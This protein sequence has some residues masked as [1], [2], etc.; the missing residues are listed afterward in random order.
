MTG[1][2]V[3]ITGASSGIGA[4]LAERLA[5]DG[6]S[7]ALVARRPDAL[8]AVGERC[9]ANAMAIVPATRMASGRA[10]VRCCSSSFFCFDAATGDVLWS[11]RANG[12][13]SGSPTIIA[14]RVYFATLAQRTYALD[15]ATGHLVW[16]FPDGKYSPVVADTKRLYLVGYTRLYGLEEPT[17]KQP[18]GAARRP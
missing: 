5:R 11:F 12:P 2:V 6:A 17:P 14:G 1:T 8:R 4:A 15:A 13:I 18:R 9:G 3:V 7:V 16:T 10:R